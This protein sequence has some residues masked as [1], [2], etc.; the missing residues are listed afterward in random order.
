MFFI[1]T[2]FNQK[3]KMLIP[4]FFH[5]LLFFFDRYIWIIESTLT[6]W[7]RQGITSDFEFE[8]P[9][10]YLVTLLVHDEVGN[11]GNDII[12]ITV[13]PLVDEWPLGPIRAPD[14]GPIA[15]VDV[16]IFMNGTEYH[17]TTGEE[18]MVRPQISV[19]DAVGSAQVTVSKTGWEPMNITLT[20][21]A[22]GRPT[23]E[24]PPMIKEV[25]PTTSSGLILLIA[26]IVIIVVGVA[27]MW[28]VQ[29]KREPA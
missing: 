14:G 27:I 25:E 1:K 23:E 18:G 28:I 10:D 17:E 8:Q 4:P 16:V 15:G 9:G 24:L 20:L 26:V 22:D 19:F 7:M 2:T 11:V 6:D 21:D 5:F 12:N 29:H 13:L 3:I